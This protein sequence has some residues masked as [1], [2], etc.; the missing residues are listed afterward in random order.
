M[1]I[2]FRY[3][4]QDVFL[5]TGLNPVLV[6]VNRLSRLRKSSSSFRHGAARQDL[7][8][9]KV[10][11]LTLREPIGDALQLLCRLAWL[12]PQC[13]NACR[14]EAPIRGPGLQ[15]EQ[16]ILIKLLV[17]FYRLS[18]LSDPSAHYELFIQHLRG[19]KVRSC[20]A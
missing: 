20:C 7:N 13:F 9:G 17:Q 5:I 10:S 12:Q 8:G 4:P 1:P 15:L 11:C 2:F 3:E 19:R 6:D 18:K 16:P 14:D